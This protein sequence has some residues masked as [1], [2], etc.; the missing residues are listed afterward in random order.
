MD[1]EHERA[2]PPAD[3]TTAASLVCCA[4]LPRDNSRFRLPGRFIFRGCNRYVYWHRDRSGQ[5]LE[6]RLTQSAIKLE[7]GLVVVD[8]LVQIL[9][10]RLRQGLF[11]DERLK[12]IEELFPRGDPVG[13]D[14]KTAKRLQS[15]A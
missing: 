4:R 13:G 9:V 5:T 3:P 10:A 15:L 2:T 12:R 14:L 6:R 11:G 1:L 7:L 8:D